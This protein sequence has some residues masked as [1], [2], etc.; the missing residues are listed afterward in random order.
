MKKDIDLL[1]KRSR[2][3]RDLMERAGST[4]LAL[5]GLIGLLFLTVLVW[6][7]AKPTFIDGE[8][9]QIEPASEFIPVS[10]YILKWD[11]P[12]VDDNGELIGDAVVLELSWNDGSPQTHEIT[13][14]V[15]AERGLSEDIIVDSSGVST[16]AVEVGKKTKFYL[17]SSLDVPVTVEQ[18]SGPVPAA[19]PTGA[20]AVGAFVVSGEVDL[21]VADGSLVSTPLEIAAWVALLGAILLISVPMPKMLERVERLGGKERAVKYGPY[22]LAA[23]TL[24]LG[25]FT[26][27]AWLGALC[28]FVVGVILVRLLEGLTRLRKQGRDPTQFDRLKHSIT[29]RESLLMWAKMLFVFSTLFIPLAIT[30]P[31]LTERY[32]DIFIPYASGIRSAFFGTIWVMAI[33]ML[34][35]M[36]VSIGAAIYLEEY[37]RPTRTTKLIQ[38]L[39]TNL[40]G[41]PSIVFGMFGLA[42]FVKQGG[43][44]LGLGPSILAAGLTMGVMAMPIIVLASQEALRSVPRSLRESAYGVGCTQWQVTRDHVLPSAMPGI[45]TGSILAMSRIMGEAAPLVV[46][47]AAALVLFDPEPLAGLTGGNVNFTVIPIQI[48]FWTSEADQAFH[49]MAAAASITLIVLLAAM[50]SVAIILREHFRRRLNP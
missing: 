45:M 46:V 48:Y 47:G 21:L 39:V 2:V 23:A 24:V 50:N 30:I 17:L 28:W 3:R 1:K 33:A 38:A 40:A 25:A 16:N 44:G 14:T 13:I 9:G 6:Q 37:A 31:F 7:I 11:H 12:T 27:D 22:L 34:V 20:P 41:V 10:D 32:Q 4:G 15:T 43:V 18:V 49:S 35:S 8:S 36:P 5:S 26:L 19:D 29:N 42:I